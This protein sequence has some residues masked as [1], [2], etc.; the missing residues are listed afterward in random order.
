MFLSCLRKSE[1]SDNV[2]F[3]LISHET[4]GILKIRKKLATTRFTYFVLV[5]YLKKK[6]NVYSRLEHSVETNFYFDVTVA[7]K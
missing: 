2:R 6:V 7:Y 4:K 3:S 5:F 1:T